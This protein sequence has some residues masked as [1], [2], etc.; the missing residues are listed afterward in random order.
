MICD[1]ILPENITNPFPADTPVN[2]RQELISRDYWWPGM[3]QFIN[4]FV[5]GCILCQQMKIDTHPNWPA[6][7]PISSNAM[8]PFAFV[9]VDFMTDLPE[10]DRSDSIMVMIDHG[11]IK[12]IVSIPCLKTINTTEMA[13]L[14]L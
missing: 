12:G 11:L 8:Q 5:D 13:D 3:M 10:S 14:F 7:Q 6:L 9:T 4:K 1:V 2:S